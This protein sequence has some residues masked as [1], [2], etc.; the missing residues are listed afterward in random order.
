MAPRDFLMPAIMSS[1]ESLL[2]NKWH[3]LDDICTE[4]RENGHRGA[5]PSVRYA[6]QRMIDTNQIVWRWDYGTSPR[7]RVYMLRAE[8]L[9]EKGPS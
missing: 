9:T 2:P 6:L 5:K 3:S 8:T 4:L 1:L 7:H